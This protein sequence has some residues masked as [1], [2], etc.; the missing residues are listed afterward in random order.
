MGLLRMFASQ[1]YQGSI[2][3]VFAENGEGVGCVDPGTSDFL[4]VVRAPAS[5]S[6]ARNAGLDWVRANGGGA[7]AMWDDDD[8]YGP[9]YLQEAVLGMLGSG[10]ALAG[11]VPHFVMFPDGLYRMVGGDEDRV[12]QRAVTGG[13]LCGLTADGLPRF[14][15]ELRE[16][17]TFCNAARSLGQK[18]WASSRRGYC[19]DRSEPGPRAWAAGPATAKRGLSEGREMEFYGAVPPEACDDPGLHPLRVVPP[20]APSEIFQEMR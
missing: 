9:D 5:V 4:S 3:I 18:I 8:W 7:W 6:A 1:R 14:E 16:D 2:R 20:V 13:T 12:T 15:G 11:K 10:C 17:V 19:Y